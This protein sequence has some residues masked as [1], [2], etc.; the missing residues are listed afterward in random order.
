MIVQE[1]VATLGLNVDEQAFNRGLLALKGLGLGLAGIGAAVGTAVVGIGALVHGTAEAGAEIKGLAETAN[2]G[3]DFFQGLAYAAGEVGFQIDDLRDVFLDL[4]ERASDAK[5]GAE[6]YTKVFGDLGVKVTDTTGKL[7]DGETLIREVADAFSKMETGTQK[8]ALASKLLGETGARLLPVLSQGSAGLDEYTNKAREAGAIMSGDTLKAAVAFRAESVKL[9]AAVSGLRNEIGA[10][11]LPL[12]TE[13]VKAVSAWIRA[14]RKMITTPVIKFFRALADSAMFV[15]RNLDI[16]KG[17][18]VVVASFLIASYLTSLGAVT[19]MQWQFGMAALISG[20]RAAAGWALA[21]AAMLLSL[22]P[23]AAL[24]ALIILIGDEIWTFVEGGDTLLGRWIKW[25]DSGT[26]SG[27]TLLEIFKALGSV[28]FDITDGKKWARL[29]N[30]IKEGVLVL[31]DKMLDGLEWISDK[32]LGTDFAAQ[33][34]AQQADMYRARQRGNLVE[35][36]AQGDASPFV[37]DFLNGGTG[38]LFGPNSASPAA[39]LAASPSSSTGVYSPN[40]NAQV[41]V[42]VG[43]GASPRQTGD[44]VAEAVT[45]QWW[46]APDMSANLVAVDQ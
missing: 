16:L 24:I 12:F 19:A 35:L 28:I 23:L 29:G 21:N 33:R 36:G 20:A 25:L 5:D 46:G 40:V 41:T 17:V 4:S 7:K 43:D 45:G 30:A 10:D 3:S 14:N 32:F 38:V 9:E 26:E 11:L 39:S 1:L 37:P 44:A 27:S 15:K 34:D 2:V 6:E 42:N 8:A 22:A 18:L 31:L 13:A